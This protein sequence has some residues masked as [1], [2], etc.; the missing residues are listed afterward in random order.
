MYGFKT[1]TPYLRQ[2]EW[3]REATNL[4][5]DWWKALRTCTPQKTA[6]FLKDFNE[7][8]A[9]DPNEPKPCHHYYE[10]IRGASTPLLETMLESNQ[11]NH[12]PI[13]LIVQRRIQTITDVSSANFIGDNFVS[14]GDNFLGF[15]RVH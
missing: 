4:W 7:L 3:D 10:R 2:V 12:D 11:V 1:I 15:T 13:T 5:T 9:T 14:I 8:H 6:N